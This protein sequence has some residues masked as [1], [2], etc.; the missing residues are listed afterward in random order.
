M[1]VGLR[2]AM[3]HFATGVTVVTTVG[4]DG[5]PCGTTANAVTSLSLDPP[6]LLVCFSRKSATFGAL[7]GHGSFAV[8]VLGSDQEALA[9]LFAAPGAPQPWP[10]SVVGAGQVPLL[11]GSLATLECRV[12]ELVP[13]GDHYIVVGRVTRAVVDGEDAEPLLFF[14]RRF[15]RVGARVLP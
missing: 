13:G 10:A 2:E 9:A 4:A 8:N 15:T 6:L 14:R 5:R 11:E 1:S 7:L 12:H 3:S